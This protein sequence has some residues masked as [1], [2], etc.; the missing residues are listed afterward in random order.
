MICKT[1]LIGTANV[2]LGLSYIQINFVKSDTYK[3]LYVFLQLA[4][5]VVF[6]V[7]TV[8]QISEIEKH[9]LT[10]APFTPTIHV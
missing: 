10:K 6:L 2:L 4:Q 9:I 8:L 3:F 1:V 7:F 5:S